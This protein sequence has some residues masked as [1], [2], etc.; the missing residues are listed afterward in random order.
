M[1]F[2]FP[3][4]GFD[5]RY[6]AYSIWMLMFLLLSITVFSKN[7]LD[8]DRIAVMFLG[9]VYIGIGFRA[10]IDVRYTAD[11]H[12]LFWTFLLFGC[13]WASDSGAYFTGRAFGKNK[14]SPSISPNKTVEGALGGVIISVIVALVFAWFAPELLSF[15]RAI[16][17][18]VAAS[19]IG[20]LGDLI[21][22][23]YKRIR[24]IKDSGSLLPGHGGVL[25]R[26]D[27]W[28]IVFPFVE[29]FALLP[30]S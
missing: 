15:S 28:I 13:I 11:N 4:Q 10:M 29:L 25:D 21:Q 30:Y 24:G 17:I 16:V 19:V 27:S 23:A 14:L 18:G 6:D 9:A 26:C 3:W 8:I 1:Y 20:Q 12:G 2:V 7:R 5:I 22:S